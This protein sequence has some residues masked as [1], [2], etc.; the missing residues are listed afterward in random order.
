MN[1]PSSNHSVS[2]NDD[3]VEDYENDVSVQDSFL[4][5]NRQEIDPMEEEFMDVDGD[6]F[7]LIPLLQSLEVPLLRIM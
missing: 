4:D 7:D 2:V 6:F 5:S 3:S 1:N